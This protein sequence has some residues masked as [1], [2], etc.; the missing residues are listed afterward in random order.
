MGVVRLADLTSTRSYFS[1]APVPTSKHLAF[2]TSNGT[3]EFRD[4][5][6]LEVITADGDDTKVV[7][8]VQS[9]FGY[10]R[11]G[12]CERVSPV[13]HDFADFR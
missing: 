9:G 11:Q 6:T 3:V 5:E 1:M 8:L 13:Y 4:R 10:A 7:S 2:T 12:E